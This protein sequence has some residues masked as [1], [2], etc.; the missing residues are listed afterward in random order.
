MPE[1]RRR[2]DTHPFEVV[3]LEARAPV[4]ELVFMLRSASLEQRRSTEWQLDDPSVAAVETDFWLPLSF[5]PL[6]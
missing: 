4:R 6:Q 3:H 1:R 2:G 5:S